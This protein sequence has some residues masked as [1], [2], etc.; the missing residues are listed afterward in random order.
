MIFRILMADFSQIRSSEI[1]L[2]FMIIFSN[3]IVTHFYLILDI[4]NHNKYNLILY[5]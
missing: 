2:V 4:L 5:F 3:I 1:L